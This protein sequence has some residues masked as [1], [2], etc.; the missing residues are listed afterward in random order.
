MGVRKEPK[1]GEAEFQEQLQSYTCLLGAGFLMHPTTA[2]SQAHQRVWLHYA[3]TLEVTPA[4]VPVSRAL[5]GPARCRPLCL[6]P[7]H[8]HPGVATLH[9]SPARAH[10][11]LLW[12]SSPGCS[13][14]GDGPRGGRVS[15]ICMKNMRFLS[16]F[17]ILQI[18]IF[19]H[20][21]AVKSKCR[22]SFMGFLQRCDTRIMSGGFA[23]VPCR[24]LCWMD[25]VST[26][27]LFYLMQA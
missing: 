19:C 21:K 27:A 23:L 25:L 1:A 2:S 13:P 5:L 22:L 24:K 20:I 8:A 18:A 7:L 6:Q 15:A 3:C 14:S 10:H 11:H 4:A 16:W 12:H 17:S 9:S 26:D